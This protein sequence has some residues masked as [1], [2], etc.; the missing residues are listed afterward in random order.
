MRTSWTILLIL[1]PAL[2]QAVVCQTVGDDGEV[3]FSNIDAEQCPQDNRL[4]GYDEPRPT[5]DAAHRAGSAEVTG[6][7]IDFAGYREVSFV[8]PSADG[9][10]RDNSG[11]FVA[12]LALDPPLR[13]DHF[14]VVDVDGRHY[15][16]RYGSEE[17]TVEGLTQGTHEISA[18]VSD[19]HGR[20]LAET[21]TLKFTLL[22]NT[23]Q[24]ILQVRGITRQ[25]GGGYLVEGVLGGGP[26]NVG[27][28]VSIRFSSDGS[29]YTG[30]VGADH[31]WA[32]EVGEE[33]STRPEFTVT[34][35]T[36]S[37]ARF[38]K[39]QRI[40]S[41]L[42]QGGYAPRVSP[43]YAPAGTGISTTPGQTNPAFSPNY[44]PS[45]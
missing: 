8:N 42:L 39:V 20:T 26:T 1:M 36:P 28:T 34:A 19:A 9:V 41:T 15:R 6:R 2:A 17:V 3:S 22:R 30:K 23:R 44:A 38:E 24:R 10:L 16:G 35:T 40:D 43:G 12:R 29:E 32:I 13:A 33:P 37:N 18:S 25:P 4:R 27:S 7:S 31:N 45:R 21:A 14:L 11:S 5:D